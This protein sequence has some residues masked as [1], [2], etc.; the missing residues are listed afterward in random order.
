M[1]YHHKIKYIPNYKFFKRILTPFFNTA[2]NGFVAIKQ[3]VKNYF[4]FYKL[5]MHR[6][7]DSFNFAK[8]NP[9]V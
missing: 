9:N 8:H 4:L 7:P 6:N 2:S 5:I 1:I 3:K